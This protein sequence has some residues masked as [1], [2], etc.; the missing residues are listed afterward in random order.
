M[1]APTKFKDSF[2]FFKQ[3]SLQLES[4]DVIDFSDV[5]KHDEIFLYDLPSERPVEAFCGLTDAKH[6][7][8]YGH[9]QFPGFWFLSNPFQPGFQK[10]WI[11]RCVRCYHENPNICNLD[12]L[13]QR[14]EGN[15]WDEMLSETADMT[16]T[17]MFKLRWTTL[18]YH[19]D[20]N[21][22]LYYKDKFTPFPEDLGC[23][24]KY[25][26]QSLGY[27][28]FQAEAAIIN[29]YH[30][31]S[32]LSGHT[33][34]SEYDLTA[35]LLSF[36]FGPTAIFLLGGKT[37][38]TK[39]IAMYCRSGDIIVM[40][41]ESRLAYHAVPKILPISAHE[42]KDVMFSPNGTCACKNVSD[43][44]V[45]FKECLMK[46]LTDDDDLEYWAPHVNYLLKSRINMNVRQVLKPGEGFPT[47]VAED[48]N[49]IHP[50]KVPK[51]SKDDPYS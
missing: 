43:A 51:L 9:K 42:L 15:L 19:Y 36:S 25:I 14:G 40:A 6:W 1:A 46:N 45:C 5:E 18:G 22:K 26:T 41:G 10:Y 12:S 39:P 13:Q 3:K 17:S 33:D 47:L 48:Q 20:W 21:T 24:A 37:K 32:T 29:Y 44:T 30:L 4:A 50:C 38:E 28:Q 35:P 31:D 11:D 49:D 16:K 27:E 7:K 2:K 8:L 23:L 34:H